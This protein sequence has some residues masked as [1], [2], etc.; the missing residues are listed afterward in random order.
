[1]LRKSPLLS[2]LCY[3]N[4]PT[5]YKL[6]PTLHNPHDSHPH[7]NNDNEK[8]THDGYFSFADHRAR[9]GQRPP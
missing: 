6:Y 1:M 5:N 9:D 3:F 8:D 4:L 7:S 2:A